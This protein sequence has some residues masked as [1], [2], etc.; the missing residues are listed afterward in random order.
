MMKRRTFLQKTAL[1]LSV[2]PFLSSFGTPSKS[3]FDNKKIL[4]VGAGMAGL[5]AASYLKKRG[6]ETVILEA[7]A[8]IGGRIQ[9]DRSLDVPFDKGASW[10]HGPQGNPISNLLEKSGA[11]TFLTNDELVGVFDVNGAEYSDKIL[12]KAEQ[13]YNKILRTFKGNTNQSFEEVFYK[14]YPEYTDNRLWT[15]ML[16]AFLEFDTGADLQ[17]L[18]SLDFYDDEAF[19]GDDLII[20][21]GFDHLT[22][23]LA[24]DLAIEVNSP[25]TAIDYSK[26]SIFIQSNQKNYTA[27]F[28]ILTVPLGVLKQNN[29]SFSPSLPPQTTQAIQKLKM[30]TVNKFLCLWEEAFWDT[31][32][33]YI[34]YT[35][36]TKGKFN[37]FLNTKKFM[38]VNGLMSFA[39]GN[40]SKETERQSDAEI[41]SEI[42]VNLSTIYG[43]NI[44]NPSQFLRT[45]WNSNPYAYGAYSF[46]SHG[47]RSADFE[48][49]EKPIEDKLFFAG[50]HTS[51]AYRG[52]VHGAYL[53]GIR[54]AKAILDLL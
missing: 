54:A 1:A 23:Y 22:N 11:K 25:V 28:V 43:S 4:I 46:A 36:K 30:G 37:Y 42:M 16:S 32:L 9:T 29:I 8:K 41:I 14:T 48:I 19:E 31:K 12:Q 13:Q 39:F 51:R 38:P 44:P 15:Y 6:I 17:E 49:F 34:G 52:T 53:S 21:N 40:S 10:I 7:Q 45:K 50:E 24:K 33:Q 20:T 47:T 5:S 27:D 3:L 35:S 18:S 2:S 26:E